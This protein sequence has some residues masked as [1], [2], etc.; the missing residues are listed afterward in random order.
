M[1]IYFWNICSSE[2]TFE[3]ILFLGVTLHV[4]CISKLLLPR[5]NIHQGLL[6]KLH[7]HP[8][9][10]HWK[11]GFWGTFRDTGKCS[12]CNTELRIYTHT[13][14]YAN[15]SWIRKDFTPLFLWT[16]RIGINF[17]LSYKNN[18]WEGKSNE[19]QFS[20]T[21]QKYISEMYISMKTHE[22]TLFF[23]VSSF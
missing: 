10:R 20:L 23:A 14:H 21:S 5:V 12:V 4:K 11:G 16:F 22:V 3:L 6:H 9:M 2:N 15:N 19:T 18:R 13:H 1:Q 17:F 7:I 8:I